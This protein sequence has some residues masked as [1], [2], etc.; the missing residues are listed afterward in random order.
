[1]AYLK[2]R[3]NYNGTRPVL[4]SLM[5]YFKSSKNSMSPI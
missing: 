1:M 3:Q 4:R 5:A 2:F